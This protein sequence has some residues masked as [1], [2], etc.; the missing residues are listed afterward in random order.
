[1][2]IRALIDGTGLSLNACAS[3]L[4]VDT[5]I[6]KEWADGKREMPPSYA[7]TLSAILG[8]NSKL[9]DSR[10]TDLRKAETP[11]IWFKL[12]GDEFTDADRESILLIRRLGHNLNQF[13]RATDGQSNR[14]WEILFERIRAAVNLQDSPQAQGRK[15]AEAFRSFTQFGLGGK[16]AAEYLRGAVRAKGILVLESPIS[17]SQL[18]GCT[19]LVGETEMQRPCIFVNTYKSTWFRRNVIIMHEL[20]HAIL[21]HNL[22][23]AIDRIEAEGSKNSRLNSIQEVRAEA[24][25]RECL[26]PKQLVMSF[27]AQ[28]GAKPTRLAPESLAGL[29]AFSGVE[30]KTV[31]AL[32]REYELI[33]DSL[34]AQYLLFE[35]WE[36]LRGMTEHALSTMQFI[37][38]IG[39]QAAQQWENKRYTTVGTRK[40]M[41]PVNYVQSVIEAVVGYKI[42]MSRATE[43]LMIDLEVF[44]ERFG[45]LMPAAAE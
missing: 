9:F 26:L 20:A 10:T 15:A 31:V 30:Q 13:E 17:G 22:G 44:L 16:G 18:E 29:V 37:E 25:A 5:Q 34:A 4:G 45:H 41:L 8:V 36:I 19:F 28:T 43:L 21:D 35:I 11:A 1:M 23:V 6:F 24:F 32:L 38:R 2:S 7:E 27:C 42:S 12:R 39:A 3:T 33:D 14:G 40:I